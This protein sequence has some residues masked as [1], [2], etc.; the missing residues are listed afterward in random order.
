MVEEWQQI[1]KDAISANSLMIR[2]PAYGEKEFSSLESSFPGDSMVSLEWA[3]AYETLNEKEKA[4]EKFREAEERFRPTDWKDTARYGIARMTGGNIEKYK[5][6]VLANVFYELHSYL[7]SE[8]DEEVELKYALL[9]SIS[10]IDVESFS[11][12]ILFRAALEKFLWN[13]IECKNIEQTGDLYSM[14]NN[15]CAKIPEAA[16]VKNAMHRIRQAGNAK[17]HNNID[18]EYRELAEEIDGRLE[19]FMN[20]VRFYKSEDNVKKLKVSF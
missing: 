8:K 10:R 18:A 13:I 1:W 20:I 12:L 17:V 15:V 16:S 2:E 6:D 7:Y 14:I 9:N 4:I 11:A 19:D 3:F 5:E